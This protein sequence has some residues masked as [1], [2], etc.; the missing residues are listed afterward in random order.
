M[1]KWQSTYSS[2]KLAAE[3]AVGIIKSGQ[4]VFL[5]GNCAV[6]QTLLRA[7]VECAPQLHDVEII[8]SADDWQFRLCKP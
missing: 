5:S 1:F 3:E 4:R 2:R 8:Q 6:P 7:L